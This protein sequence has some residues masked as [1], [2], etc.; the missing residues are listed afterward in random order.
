MSIKALLAKIDTLLAPVAKGPESDAVKVLTDV[1]ERLG[2]ILAKVQESNGAMPPGMAA[3]ITTAAGMLLGLTG[4][5]PAPGA[6][7]PATTPAG[8]PA[9]APGTARLAQPGTV[10]VVLS[11]ATKRALATRLSKAELDAYTAR[12]TTLN[13]A[14]ER[15]WKMKSFFAEG[16]DAEGNAELK[17]IADMLNNAIAAGAGA[18]AADPLAGAQK[19][20]V[21]FTQEQ[22]AAYALGQV[23][24]AATEEKTEAV[25]RL[26]HL[27]AVS[28]LAK[29]WFFEGTQPG[30]PWQ[31]EISTAYAPEGDGKVMDLTTTKDQSQST[32]N[33]T[34]TTDGTPGGGGVFKAETLTKVDGLLTELL[35]QLGAPPPPPEGKAAG[36]PPGTDPVQKGDSAFGWP[37]DMAAAVQEEDA[38]AVEKKRGVQKSAAAAAEAG[39]GPFGF[40]PWHPSRQRGAAR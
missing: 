23:Q 40:D 8:V 37:N 20:E 10:P 19:R 28:A 36:D 5:A 9:A 21:T 34:A 35:T 26:T 7:V 25:K 13:A 18:A 24:K 2:A 4:E 27:R 17:G 29:A 14:N 6:A 11:S 39:G 1:Y 12:V 22:F 3:E 33:I 32:G 38:A 16:K 30:L 15:W 31:V